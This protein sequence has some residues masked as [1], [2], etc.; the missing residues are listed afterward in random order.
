MAKKTEIERLNIWKNRMGWSKKFKEPLIKEYQSFIK[1]FYG[2]QYDVL[3]ET[4]LDSTTA[5]VINLIFSHIKATLPMLYFQNPRFYLDATGLEY[6]ER[7]DVAEEVLNYVV[8]K[9]K[10]KR[11]IRLATLDALFL[12]G[13]CKTGYNPVFCWKQ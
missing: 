4:S 13:V 3:K 2:D 5:I 8:K 11:E 9:E 10:L 1:Y 12:M 6:E 7:K